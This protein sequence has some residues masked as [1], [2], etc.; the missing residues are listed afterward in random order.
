MRIKGEWSGGTTHYIPRSSPYY[1]FAIGAPVPKFVNPCRES[2][3]KTLNPVRAHLSF[4][5]MMINMADKCLWLP[6]PLY[7]FRNVGCEG[8]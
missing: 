3:E 5:E 1:L 8:A 4:S 6:H 7:K 2:L